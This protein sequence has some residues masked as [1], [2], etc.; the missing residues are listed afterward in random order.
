MSRYR[1]IEVKTW[2]DEKF[3]RLS[4]IPPCGQGLWLYLLSGP[5]T[6]PIP[7]LF[8]AGR[9]SLAEEL[10]WD[11]KAFDKAF[12]ELADEGMVKGDAGTRLIWIPNA[13][14]H[15]PPASPNVIKAWAKEFDLLPESETKDQA[16]RFIESF[17]KGMNG[18]FVEAFVKAFRQA[19]VKASAKHSVKASGIPLG[20]QE[21]EQ[22]QDS[23]DPSQDKSP[24]RIRGG[25]PAG[26]GSDCDDAP[27]GR[28][29]RA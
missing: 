16:L 12:K 18:A 20:N 6:G 22:E 23:L 1:K 8:R 28:E 10:G 29:G 11:L 17:V 15:N 13:I 9:A 2:G 4:R 25:L 26:D 21:Q 19:L 7:G 27:F 3:C 24:H 14:R 5:H